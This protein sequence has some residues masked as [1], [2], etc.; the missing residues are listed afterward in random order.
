[1]WKGIY[2]RA[3]D[4]RPVNLSEAASYI[5]Q[6]MQPFHLGGPLSVDWIIRN[7][8]I[9]EW[10]RQIYVDLVEDITETGEHSQKPNWT[11]PQDFN[12]SMSGYRTSTCIEVVLAMHAHGIATERSLEHIASIWQP[13]DPGSIDCSDLF[14]SIKETLS[15]VRLDSEVVAVQAADLH[16]P[17]PLANWPRAVR[18]AAEKTD[19]HST[20]CMDGWRTLL[21]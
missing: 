13:I 19:I 5:E 7:E 20:S 16:S 11:A 4:W 17:S 9:G 15:A 2:T 1:M 21:R 3:C 18:L 12:S 14:A 6:G 10:E 8:T